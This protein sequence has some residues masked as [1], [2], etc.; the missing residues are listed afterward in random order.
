MRGAAALPFALLTLVA[1][2]GCIEDAALSGK[3]CDSAHACVAGFSCVNGSCLVDLGGEG[4][5]EG[6]AG[7]GEGSEGE[8][9]EGEGAEG[10]G[11]GAEG[12][13]EGEGEGGEGEGGAAGEGEGAAAGEGEGA[14]AGEGEGE[15]APACPNAVGH[16]EDGDGIDDACDNCPTV[17]N[18]DQKDTDGDG[19]GDACDPN[20]TRP[21]DKI[22]F[23]DSFAEATLD[24]AWVG[25]GDVGI[26]DFSLGADAL[27]HTD[28]S[29]QDFIVRTDVGTANTLVEAKVFY[30]NID[31][32]AG[33]FSEVGILTG[34]TVAS[35]VTA[36]DCRVSATQGANGAVSLGHIAGG[37][38]QNPPG[39]I[40]NRTLAA[41]PVGRTFTQSA[42]ATSQTDCALTDDSI[43]A[44]DATT[45]VAGG[46][47]FRIT[48]ANVDIQS[49]IVYQLGP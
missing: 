24:P 21:G 20:P 5:G 49:V 11:E 40:G 41:T 12:E 8:G 13:G 6:L 29:K 1:S 14:A 15:G 7:E 42:R 23:F 35:P 26:G 43:D 2:A 47:G 28:N 10:E 19:V 34:V 36:V 16:D 18:F 27:K 31:P 33:Q 44:V 38:F 17:A 46:F 4:E 30:E 32:T 25:S 22:L 39:S 9:A 45:P 3:R 48:H 37:N